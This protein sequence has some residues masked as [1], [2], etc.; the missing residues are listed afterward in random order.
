MFNSQNNKQE[1]MHTLSPLTPSATMGL[2][3]SWLRYSAQTV[4][5][6]DTWAWLITLPLWA[7]A[8]TILA[9]GRDVPERDTLGDDTPTGKI[10]IYFFIKC[11]LS[12]LGV[13]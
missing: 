11:G 3:R 2:A 6:R 10:D 1:A 12:E 5:S 9:A 13:D 4:A 8:D 7:A